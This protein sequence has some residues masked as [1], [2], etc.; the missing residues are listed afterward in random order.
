MFNFPNNRKLWVGAAGTGILLVAGILA[1]V[2]HKNREAAEAQ[3]H[4]VKQAVATPKKVATPKAVT[5]STKVKETEPTQLVTG[6][7]GT[8]IT[9][10]LGL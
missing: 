10:T 1:A 5:V 9:A 8:A 3:N 7:K 6:P 4:A 2:S